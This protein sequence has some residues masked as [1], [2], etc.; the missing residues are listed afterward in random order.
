MTN[1]TSKPSIWFW[2]ISVIALFWNFFGVFQYLYTAYNQ[3]EMLETMTQ[4]QREVFETIPA[5]AT[6][7]FAIA[8][9]SGTIACIALLL[10][11]KWAKP[12]FIISFITAIAQFINWLFIQNAAEV[13]PNSYAM[14]ITVTI[15]GLLLIMFSNKSIQNG[16]L[17]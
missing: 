13:F 3:V 9:F 6:A 8:V 4:V 14:P 17:K 11:K 16:W 15:I 5:W 2:V 7:C 10:R 12:L 1:S